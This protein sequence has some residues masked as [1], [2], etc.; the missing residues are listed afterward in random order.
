MTKIEIGKMDRSG[1]P[2]NIDFVFKTNIRID[3]LSV[4]R[5]E[6]IKD[7]SGPVISVK[8]NKDKSIYIE[9]DQNHIDY[10][11]AMEK[12]YELLPVSK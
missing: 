10:K 3:D 1:Y 6:L 2:N 7:T 4:L 5:A 9:L 8:P 11:L 12:I